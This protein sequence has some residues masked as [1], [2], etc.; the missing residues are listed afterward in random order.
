M[1]SFIEYLLEG[2]DEKK[3]AFKIKIAGDLPENCEDCMESAL[4]KYKVSRFTKGKSTPIQ[5]TLLDF[6]NIKNSQMTVFEAEVDYPATSAVITEL[7]SS[8]TG[9][10]KD[11]FF[12][13]YLCTNLR[14]VYQ[15][16]W[17]FCADFS[18]RGNINSLP[19]STRDRDL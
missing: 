3:Y 10:N 6:P 8:A 2:A 17:F 19:S 18:C 13:P 14:I 7:I 9:I 5:E 16:F 12:G 4:Q 15:V 1:K 11:C